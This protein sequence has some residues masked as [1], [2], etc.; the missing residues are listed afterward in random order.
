MPSTKDQ[1]A[2]ATAETAASVIAAAQAG[3]HPWTLAQ[4]RSVAERVQ[5]PHILA[6]MPEARLQAPVPP[7]PLTDEQ[8][9]DVLETVTEAL[10]RVRALQARL[11][12]MTDEEAAALLPQ[13][14]AL[15]QQ[16]EHLRRHV[17]GGEAPSLPQ[18]LV[19]GA[20]FTGELLFPEGPRQA[21][22][23]ISRI[24]ARG[25]LYVKLADLHGQPLTV[26]EQSM[27]REKLLRALGGA[28]IQVRLSDSVTTTFR[29]P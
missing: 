17:L 1:I 7:T 14:K 27:S 22:L 21:R 29:I 16:A 25:G 11:D 20:G 26:D 4:I 10:A 12:T 5:N 6:L 28:P 19:L 3:T 15:H 18:Q 9:V 2:E 13:A 8:A 24:G 23:T